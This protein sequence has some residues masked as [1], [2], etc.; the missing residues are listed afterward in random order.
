MART[1]RKVGYESMPDTYTLRRMDAPLGTFDVRSRKIGR[2]EQWSTGS[3]Y[4]QCEWYALCHTVEVSQP[5]DV[6]G[7]AKVE[8]S[9]PHKPVM[10]SALVTKYPQLYAKKKPMIFYKTRTKIKNIISFKFRN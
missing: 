4:H 8:E 6:A 7:R 9:Y 2:E 5:G 10:R 1:D 3:W